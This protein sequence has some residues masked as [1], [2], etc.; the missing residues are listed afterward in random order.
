MQAKRFD[1]GQAQAVARTDQ[2]LNVDS[3]WLD[4]IPGFKPEPDAQPRARIDKPAQKQPKEL[5]LP[6]AERWIGGGVIVLCV[7]YLVWLFAWP[8]LRVNLL[9]EYE[10]RAAAQRRDKAAD[11]Y[12]PRDASVKLAEPVI[13]KPATQASRAGAE[14]A[15]QANQSAAQSAPQPSRPEDLFQPGPLLPLSQAD[16][17][18]LER[19]PP[20]E[21]PEPGQPHCRIGLY[22][23][24]LADSQPLLSIWRSRNGLY[25]LILLNDGDDGWYGQAVTSDYKQKTARLGGQEPSLPFTVKFKLLE[26]GRTVENSTPREID[27][28]VT[29]KP[30]F[31]EATKQ[32]SFDV[33]TSMKRYATMKAREDCASGTLA[34]LSMS[35]ELYRFGQ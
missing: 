12:S 27:I 5:G 33:K 18:R 34:Y 4:T 9:S 26:P 3:D 7:F 24:S 29:S 21:I 30:V 13:A 20:P 1:S 17:A 35:P 14:P 28:Q 10:E 19:N 2:S 15:S 31:S 11:R 6:V 22:A 25:F 23:N 16:Y 8:W 32:A